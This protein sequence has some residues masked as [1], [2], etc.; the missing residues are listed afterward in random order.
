MSIYGVK[1][2]D[3]FIRCVIMQRRSQCKDHVNMV[4]CVGIFLLFDIFLDSRNK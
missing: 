3:N 1:C 2:F 4:F